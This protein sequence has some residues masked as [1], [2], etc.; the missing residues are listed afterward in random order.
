MC[1]DTSI[2]ARTDASSQDVE[3]SG[4]SKISEENDGWH[5][6]NIKY[7]L[8]VFSLLGNDP[9]VS[10]ESDTYMR[11]L[12]I[13]GSYFAKNLDVAAAIY[14]EQQARSHEGRYGLESFATRRAYLNL[15]RFHWAMNK[16]PEAKAV[17][18][19]M[20]KRLQTY[21]KVAPDTYLI[22]KMLVAD[23]DCRDGDPAKA[24][25]LYGDLAHRYTLHDSPSSR[26]YHFLHRGLQLFYTG[27]SR[28]REALSHINRATEWLERVPRTLEHATETIVERRVALLVLKAGMFEA[29][30]QDQ[31]A[32]R[33]YSDLI[34]LCEQ[35]L[36]EDPYIASW[37]AAADDR[38][39]TLNLP[40]WQ[41]RSADH[42]C[43]TASAT[44]A[45][46]SPILLVV[47]PVWTQGQE[48]IGDYE[49]GLQ[50]SNS[51]STTNNIPPTLEAAKLARTAESII[52]PN[53]SVPTESSTQPTPEHPQ[54]GLS[55]VK[56]STHGHNTKIHTHDAEYT[57]MAAPVEEKLTA[58]STPLPVAE[59]SSG[60][61]SGSSSDSEDCLVRLNTT[62]KTRHTTKLLAAQKEQRARIGGNRA[63]KPARKQHITTPMQHILP[64]RPNPVAAATQGP[65]AAQQQKMPSSADP[66]SS[67]SSSM[68]RKQKLPYPTRVGRVVPSWSGFLGL[69]PE[70]YETLATHGG[71][72]MQIDSG[73]D[74]DSG[75]DT[76]SW[77]QVQFSNYHASP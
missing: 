16:F 34:V 30:G 2:S 8:W 64:L 11:L 75:S 55:R 68:A 3:M 36:G 12:Q 23:V 18:E 20:A 43:M 9:N 51:D 59:S 72:E 77:E 10:K 35:H 7:L 5:A 49:K 26:S 40:K 73:C 31:V 27:K 54:P 32:T 56:S 61:S 38:I 24:A 46:N 48:R 44:I 71:D 53:Y 13:L 70:T 67:S 76:D 42:E 25:A 50:G 1:S 69:G 60:S 52:N 15:F 19:Y 45:A 63:R 47:P 74:T 66:S 29:L 4:Y 41:E 22:W 33:V 6:G 28:W 58:E 37:H 57:E 39:S 17:A 21:L 65:S 62:P 14:L